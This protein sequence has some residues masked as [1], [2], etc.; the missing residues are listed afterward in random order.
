MLNK[1]LPKCVEKGRWRVKEVLHGPPAAGDKKKEEAP[2][3]G[4]LICW[5]APPRARAGCAHRHRARVG[6]GAPRPVAAGVLAEASAARRTAPARIA[7]R[8][9]AAPK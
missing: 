8:S 7:A 1:F 3:T 9:R 2:A 4:L 6:R 5:T